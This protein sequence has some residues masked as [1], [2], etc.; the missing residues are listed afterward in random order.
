MNNIIILTKNYFLCALGALRGKKRA[1][2]NAAGLGAAAVLFGVIV[3]LIVLQT[4]S[5]GVLL[6]GSGLESLLLYNG[7][8]LGAVLTVFF[9]LQKITGGAK[10]NDADLLL[11]MPFTRT[12]IVVA[13]AASKYLLSLGTAAMVILP[14]TIVYLAVTAFSFSVLMFALLIL[15]LIPMFALGLTYILD[16]LTVVLFGRFAAAGVLRSIFTV[17]SILAFL[18][19]YMYAQIGLN[20]EVTANPGTAVVP[21]ISWFMD[22]TLSGDLL[23]LLYTALL[24]VVPFVIG[25]VLFATTFDRQ[26]QI[27]K[28]R[29]VDIA[30]QPTKG[31]FACLFSK[32]LKQYLNNPT[33][34]VNTIIGTVLIVAMTV[35][36]VSA[37]AGSLSSLFGMPITNAHMFPIFTIAFCFLS[38]I[39]CTTSASLSLEGKYFW[40]LKTMPVKTTHVL[41]SK[42]ALSLM[43][44]SPA[45]ILCSIVILFVFSMGFVQFLFMLILP[46][47]VNITVSFGGLFINLIYPKFD[48]ESEAAVVKRSL[49]VMIASF[50][51]MFLGALPIILTFAIDATGITLPLITLAIYAALATTSVTLVFTVGKS[52]YERL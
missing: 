47:L 2:K 41:L 38:A 49:S 32:E 29:A 31:P 18:S 37:G 28:R 1:G 36:T 43:L 33:Y 27:M 7:F 20:P 42:V 6:K 44:V 50:A 9:S 11:S 3:T 45:L 12:Q 40:V 51:G 46:V 26:N 17:V 23:S 48:Y 10:S 21:P 16:Y 19:V 15:L 25:L 4:V 22:F 34:M 13:K 8:M 39:T 5:Q 24:T 30:A 35:F 14:Y 52:L